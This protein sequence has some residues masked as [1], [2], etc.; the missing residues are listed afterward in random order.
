MATFYDE[1]LRGRKEGE[2]TRLE[3]SLPRLR[4][5][6]DAIELAL[7]LPGPIGVDVAQGLVQGALEI[8]IQIAKHDA[9]ELAE[10][11][12]KKIQ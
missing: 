8:A 5:H 3:H 9:F 1:S 12:A 4:A 10:H 7:K 2:R 11:D 6:I